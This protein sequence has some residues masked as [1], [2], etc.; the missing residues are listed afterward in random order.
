[1]R[2]LAA[3][4]FF[5]LALG[6]PEAV[7]VV[8]GIAVERLH[9]TDNEAPPTFILETEGGVISCSAVVVGPRAILTVARCLNTS[10]DPGS[11][12][13]GFPTI[14]IDG[15]AYAMDTC[16]TPVT[17]EPTWA[18]CTTSD[19]DLPV[20]RTARVNLDPS[21]P[22]VGAPVSITGYGCSLK[23][24]IDREFGRFRMGLATVVTNDHGSPAVGTSGAA[25]CFG[26]SGGG[27]YATLDD[28]TSVLVGV[29]WQSNLDEF[30]SFLPTSGI[31]FEAIAGDTLVCGISLDDA[32]ACLPGLM[33]DR[34]LATPVSL[35][36]PSTTD[37]EM[38]PVGATLQD[39][40]IPA[41]L[42]DGETIRALVSRVCGPE[43]DSY[44]ESLAGRLGLSDAELD[45][46]SDAQTL[47]IPLCS[48][49][50]LSWYDERVVTP[51]F[52]LLWNFFEEQ[53]THQIDGSLRWE[54]FR[55]D[56]GGNDNP[57]NNRIFV[58]AFLTLNPGIDPDALPQGETVLIPNAPPRGSGTALGDVELQST[59]V[60]Q[61]GITAA[62][63][64]D[65]DM[66]CPVEETASTY[67]Y[68]VE[69]LLY[70][71]MAN[72]VVAP[73]Q[74]RD[75]ATVLVA[76]SGL[77]GT[78]AGI[79]NWTTVRPPPGMLPDTFVENILPVNTDAKMAHGTQVASLLLGGP[80]FARVQAIL[81]ND[82][83]VKLYPRRIYLPRNGDIVETNGVRRA[84]SFVVDPDLFRAIFVEAEAR[85]PEVIN[86]SFKR[87]APIDEIE[88]LG[89]DVD[90]DALFVAAAGNG[91]GPIR[92]G[93]SGIY[94]AMYG[95]R[96][97][98][99]VVGAVGGKHVPA[100]FSNFDKELVQISAPG[101]AVPVASFDPAAKGFR[102]E[103]QYGTSVA[104]PLVSFAAAL[105]NYE[106]ERPKPSAV[107]ERL[108]ASADLVN[109]LELMWQ[110]GR[111]LDIPKAA[112]VYVDVVEP[113]DG[114]ILLAGD[115]SFVRDGV[116]LGADDILRGECRNDAPLNVTVSNVRK[117]TPRYRLENGK[118]YAKIYFIETG[119][120]NM[121][122]REC[123]LPDTLSI[124]LIEAESRTEH[125][126]KLTD[127]FDV[128]PRMV[129]PN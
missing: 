93:A 54:A 121:T 50:D 60:A 122:R 100:P 123:V 29:N 45:Q 67:P 108:L 53:P 76:D 114:G 91:D 7:A 35:P 94:P 44:F 9:G 105:I 70:V 13:M 4:V 1:M 78:G 21:F 56:E 81:G 10:P 82:S 72:R 17:D 124:K 24:G 117:I 19:G 65:S 113:V 63:L 111:V 83:I 30:S 112:A 98:M 2:A 42:L 66:S 46:P 75:A 109:D 120:P 20:A 12:E 39:H 41:S 59:G 31:P 118:T 129:V 79:F 85:K 16:T 52:S 102:A 68:S 119:R 128:V 22:A 95:E 5:F 90:S 8:D 27:V 89:L 77:Y 6:M 116:A 74:P 36:L 106:L 64:A 73:D 92:S 96:P 32:A 104:A 125:T 61:F 37:F 15:A 28:G 101:C 3:A 55:G 88:A 107:K 49:D 115:L 48:L 51:E 80:L 40:S 86:L 127:V 38:R 58:D 47:E 23:G 11:S 84:V 97:N 69:N 71:L 62:E 57:L 110:D 103:S 18:L 26:D 126:M 33:A 43:P 34:V 14:E 25:V 87:R 99:I